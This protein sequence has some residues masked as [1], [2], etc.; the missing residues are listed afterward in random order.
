MLESINSSNSEVMSSNFFQVSVSV[1]FHHSCS[2]YL[3]GI[4][5]TIIAD[6]RKSEVWKV[7]QLSIFQTVFA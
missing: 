5:D 1:V 6:C 7:G 2:V 3:T 4:K